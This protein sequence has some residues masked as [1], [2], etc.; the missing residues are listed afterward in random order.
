MQIY[1]S[2]STD[3][4]TRPT[5]RLKLT[6]TCWLEYFTHSGELRLFFEFSRKCIFHKCSVVRLKRINGKRFKRITPDKERVRLDCFSTTHGKHFSFR[7][8]NETPPFPPRRI[9]VKRRKAKDRFASKYNRPF[10]AV[11]LFQFFW[12]N[13]FRE[14]FPP[15][16]SS[17]VF[18]RSK[19]DAR[20]TARETGEGRKRIATFNA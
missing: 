1:I 7:R 14:G 11:C 8:W 3:K 19:G 4:E 12:V 9:P 18:E 6:S 15:Y 5:Q 16:R 13:H 17:L 2:T 20:E 10:D